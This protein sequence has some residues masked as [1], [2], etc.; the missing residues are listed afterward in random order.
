MAWATIGRMSD[1]E[2]L[3]GEWS[4]HNRRLRELFA[5]SDDWYEFEGVASAR[6][7]LGGV[8]NVDE[9]DCPSEGF[10]GATVRLQDQATGDW[11]IYWADSTTGRL[12]PPVVGRF[13][14][15]RG[16]FYGDDTHRGIPIR[17]HFTWSDMTPT[18]ARWQQ[19]F[20]ADGGLT[21][22][23]NW[24]MEFSRAG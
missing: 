22:E 15:G 2:F 16:D 8:G 24:V 10:S 7:L 12:F 9:M 4:V 20:S 13:E 21:W 23:V 14:N 17:A 5:G 18:S 6:P 1:F 19:Q 3:Y 11:S